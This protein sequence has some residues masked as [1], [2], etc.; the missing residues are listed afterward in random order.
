MVL[1]GF[2]DEEAMI[3]LT[4]EIVVWDGQR[5]PLRGVPAMLGAIRQLVAS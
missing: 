3:D 2:T 5:S 4:H 1:T